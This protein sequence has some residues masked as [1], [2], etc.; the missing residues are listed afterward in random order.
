RFR[1]ILSDADSHAKFSLSLLN[2]LAGWNC[3]TS[4]SLTLHRRGLFLGGALINPLP[5]SAAQSMSASLRK[6]P[7]CCVAAKRRYVPGADIGALFQQFDL[8]RPPLLCE[9]GF[10]WTVEAQDCEP[11]PGMVCIQFPR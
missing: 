4:P 5:A 3:Q 1:A 9:E 2:G 6:R 8:A 11:L 7:N 10:E